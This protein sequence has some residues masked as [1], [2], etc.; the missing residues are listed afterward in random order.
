MRPPVVIPFDPEQSIANQSGSQDNQ[1]YNNPAYSAIMSAL[2]RRQWYGASQSDW[3]SPGQAPLPAH[4]QH[5]SHI[6]VIME[7]PSF[8]VGYP[9]WHIFLI[10]TTRGS[11]W[12]ACRKK[13]GDTTELEPQYLADINGYAFS[14][15]TWPSLPADSV[16]AEIAR[17]MMA[18]GIIV[19]EDWPDGT[20]TW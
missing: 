9:S 18:E 1:G 7:V 15:V 2:C 19:K 16:I 13:P 6:C 17:V 20:V 14:S 10:S 3:L 12:L 11:V 5:D 8:Y 4:W